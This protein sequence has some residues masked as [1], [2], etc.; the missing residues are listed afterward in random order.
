MVAG[1]GCIVAQSAAA[2]WTGD[3]E[4]GVS[5]TSGNT[6]TNV[7]NAKI[8]MDATHNRWRHNIFGDTFYSEDSGTKT[9]ERYSLGYRPRYFLTEANYVFGILRYDQDEFS[10]I[11]N[12]T[13]EIAGYGRQ[14]VN[15]A[16]QTWDAEIGAGLR[17]TDYIDDPGTEGL[18]DDEFIGFLGTKYTYKISSTAEFSETLRVEAGHDN[19]F[20]ESVTGLGTTITDS[21][22]AKLSYTVRYNSDVEGVNGDKTDTITGVNVVYNFSF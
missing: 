7:V 21:L 10:F 2:F 15:S 17:Q 6:E 5:L 22:T 18:A 3:A 14:I 8:D 4:M 16:V 12:R 20:T 19:T 11:D 13:T 9:A 1:L